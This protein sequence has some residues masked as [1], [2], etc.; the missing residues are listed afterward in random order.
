[1]ISNRMN[2]GKRAFSTTLHF[3]KARL[4]I[5]R[6]GAQM[7]PKQL[8]GQGHIAED[9]LERFDLDINGRYF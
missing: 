2:L 4:E 6:V 5:K 7:Q 9:G 8:S 3:Q 1:M